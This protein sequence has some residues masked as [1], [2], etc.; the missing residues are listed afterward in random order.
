MTF[1]PDLGYELVNPPNIPGSGFRFG[2]GTVVH[3]TQSEISTPTIRTDDV[4]VARADGLMMGR[5]YYD[6]LTITF[7]INIK[8]RGLGTM[9]PRLKLS[10]VA[11]LRLG[12]L[13]IQ[14]SVHH[15]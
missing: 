7:D 12:S 11:W 1:P 8:T 14:V 15:E 5:E 10:I 4:S 13:R 3:V 2:R 6:G 9:V